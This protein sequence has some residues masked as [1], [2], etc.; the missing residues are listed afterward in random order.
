[1]SSLFDVVY[2]DNDKTHKQL[3]CLNRTLSGFL[4][5]HLLVRGINLDLT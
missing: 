1:M 3:L 2:I 4:E 5:I